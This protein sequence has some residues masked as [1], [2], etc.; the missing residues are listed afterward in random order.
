MRATREQLGS[1]VLCISSGVGGGRWYRFIGEDNTAIATA[2]PPGG[3]DHCGTAWPGWLSGWGDITKIGAPPRGYNEPGRY[4]AFEDGILDGTACFN[5]NCDSSGDTMPVPVSVVRC[6]GG[7]R[8]ATAVGSV[9]SDAGEEDGYLLWKLQYTG[10]S[11]AYCTDRH[12]KRENPCASG[13]YTTLEDEW[14]SVGHTGRVTLPD[15]KSAM[16]TDLHLGHKCPVHGSFS[17]Q[18]VS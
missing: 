5:S 18:S 7:R 12:T 11:S 14:R 17:G 3:N 2:P 10:C 13:D 1:C 6:G 9:T 8:D 15:G 4:P 16:M